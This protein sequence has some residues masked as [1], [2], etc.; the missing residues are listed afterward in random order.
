MPTLTLAFPGKS[1][2]ATPWGSHVNEGHVEWPPSPWRICRA[3]LATGMSKLGWSA[4]DLPATGIELLTALASVLPEYRLPS[5]VTVSH[6]RHYMPTDKKS[7]KVFDGFARI[8]DA[9]IQVG[10]DVELTPDAFMLFAEL[11]EHMGYL[12]RAESWVTASVAPGPIRGPNCKA[13]A[14]PEIADGTEPVTLLAPMTQESFAAWRGRMSDSL[15]QRDG[16]SKKKA[17]TRLPEELLDCMLLSTTELHRQGWSAPPG[18]R[19]VLYTRPLESLVASVPSS[20][21]QTT[22]RPPVECALLSL[23]SYALHREVLPPL[24]LALPQMESLHRGLVSLLGDHN[25]CPELTGRDSDGRPLRDGHRHAHYIPLALGERKIDAP[26]IGDGAIDHVLIFADSGLTEIAQRALERLRWVG[27]TL[28]SDRASASPG[29][30][31]RDRAR[32]TT[33]LVATGDLTTI[34]EAI[35]EHS[36]LDLFAESRVWESYTPFIAPRFIKERHSIQTQL[37]AELASRGLPPA[38]TIE[39]ADRDIAI[40]AG[41]MGFTRH[42]R[43]GKKQPPSTRPW[44]LRLTFDAPLGGRPLALGYGSHLGLG[45]FRP[46]PSD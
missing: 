5:P 35:R 17:R 36:A 11:A 10:W 9:P 24:R 39:V 43:R 8:G 31:R 3:L 4:D 1:Y 19:R 2:H 14:T 6:S 16:A 38:L 32:L 26:R 30:R 21:R 40:A 20:R 33:T 18:T 44:S 42:R 23:S 27:S 15:A 7:T 29:E 41:F 46:I 12:G 37:Q 25:A 34:R 28:V 22:Q 13:H 45:L